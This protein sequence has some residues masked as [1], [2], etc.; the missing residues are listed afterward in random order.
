L[1]SEQFLKE[2]NQNLKSKTINYFSNNI[3]PTKNNIKNDKITD[4]KIS[5]T[6]SPLSINKSDRKKRRETLAI[7]DLFLDNENVEDLINM[8]DIYGIKEGSLSQKHGLDF[9]SLDEISFK[10]QRLSFEIESHNNIIPSS[11]SSPLLVN[12][13]PIF[14]PSV[15]TNSLDHTQQTKLNSSINTKV[16]RISLSKENDTMLPSNNEFI[17]D[18]ILSNSVNCE[19]IDEEKGKSGLKKVKK[20]ILSDEDVLK[21]KVKKEEISFEKDEVIYPNSLNDNQIVDKEEVEK[22]LTEQFVKIEEELKLKNSMLQNK[23]DHLKEDLS[24][25]QEKHQL[26][27]REKESESLKLLAQYDEKNKELL[28]ITEENKSLKQ[29]LQFAEDNKKQINEQ[30]VL[31]IIKFMFIYN[32]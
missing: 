6:S 24:K 19:N 22:V 15:K 7:K 31:I 32:K 17:N 29:E 14:S 16:K 2:F 4:D 10:K 1:E 26:L 12:S 30:Q 5:I 20:E 11:T 27:S 18:K 13:S 25:L 9:D 21:S 3:T 28:N 8:D 23:I